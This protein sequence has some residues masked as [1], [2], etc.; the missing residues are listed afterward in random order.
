LLGKSDETVAALYQYEHKCSEA[1]SRIR[2]AIGH[3][4]VALIRIHADQIRLYSTSSQSY[5]GPVLYGDLQLR[6]PR[7]VR[8]LAWNEYWMS[9]PES[10]LAELDVDRIL[11]V[12]DPNAQDKARI[13]M[14]SSNWQAMTAVKKG[15]VYKVGYYTWMSSGILMNSL[16]IDEAVRLL[17]PS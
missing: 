7:L 8:D 9:L 2:K 11:L 13:L 1:G 12:I 17:A 16:K 6:A 4:T 10:L 14:N 5:T 3:K 15:H